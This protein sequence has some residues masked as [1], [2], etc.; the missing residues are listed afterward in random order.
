MTEK[1]IYYYPHCINEE[2]R[3][4]NYAGK[5]H[6]NVSKT[7]RNAPWWGTRTL[8]PLSVHQNFTLGTQDNISIIL[9]NYRH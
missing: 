8:P 3:L 5:L 9:K 2:I 6:V 7:I 4:V 1:I